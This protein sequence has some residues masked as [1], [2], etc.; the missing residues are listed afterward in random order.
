MSLRITIFKKA[1]TKLVGVGGAGGSA[2]GWATQV[3]QTEESKKLEKTV[4][5][6][7]RGTDIQ[8]DVFGEIN[9]NS[10]FQTSKPYRLYLGFKLTLLRWK[11]GIKELPALLIQ[12]KNKSK[13]MYVPIDEA[14]I[15]KILTEMMK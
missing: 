10:T 15:L 1:V 6:I 3:V 12:S 13:V 9:P 14:E 4:R 8:V 11:Y 7:V 2:P 5:K